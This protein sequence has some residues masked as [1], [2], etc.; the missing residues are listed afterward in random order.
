MLEEETEL[1]K[2]WRQELV[3]VIY[4]G[5]KGFPLWVRLKDSHSNR[6]WLQ[7]SGRRDPEWDTDWFHWEVPKSWFNDLVERLLRRFGQLY[8]IQPYNED[9]ECCYACQNAIHHICECSCM[10]ANHGSQ[11]AGNKWFSVSEAF[12][13]SRK[14]RLLAC[15]LMRNN[16]THSAD[17]T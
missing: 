14:G 11:N 2:V 8:I 12:I 17:S 15:R 10:G 7:E 13:A 9:E 5:G 3:P 4:R 6:Q 16:L 1:F